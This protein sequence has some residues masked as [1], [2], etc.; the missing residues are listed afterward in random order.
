MKEMFI[1]LHEAVADCR[2]VAR[3]IQPMQDANIEGPGEIVGTFFDMYTLMTTKCFVQYILR[4]LSMGFSKG[5][6]ST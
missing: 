6:L 2:N 4:V 1:V 5:K 3:Q